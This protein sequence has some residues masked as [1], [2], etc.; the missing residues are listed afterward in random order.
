[1]NIVITLP[2][3]LID[4]II[5]GEKLYEMRKTVPKLMRLKEDGFFV[6]EKGTDNIRC[7][8]RVDDIFDLKMTAEMTT[9]IS[10]LV[11]VPVEYI[12]RYAPNEGHVKM[13]QIGIVKVL[14]GVRLEDLVVE[15]N[16]Q[17]FAY[18]PLSWGESF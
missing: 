18:C 6:V 17:T 12:N 13:W 5:S 1:M 2:A 11:S 9:S 10:P 3:N 7:W 16:P 14:S 8:C 4:A 15:R